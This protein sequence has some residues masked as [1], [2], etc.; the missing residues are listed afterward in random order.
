MLKP[1]CAKAAAYYPKAILVSSKKCGNLLTGREF[2]HQSGHFPFFISIFH[3]F[4][5]MAECVIGG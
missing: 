4:S 1:S 3:F 2:G 5:M